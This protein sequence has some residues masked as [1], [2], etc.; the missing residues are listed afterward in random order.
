MLSCTLFPIPCLTSGADEPSAS[1][2]HFSTALGE[3]KAVANLW[4]ASNRV[5]LC[6]VSQN[7]I[8][9]E[10]GREREHAKLSADFS[11]QERLRRVMVVSDYD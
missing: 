9:D 10:G 1:R 7:D 8:R 2:M 5:G 4:D 3:C 6:G 11:E